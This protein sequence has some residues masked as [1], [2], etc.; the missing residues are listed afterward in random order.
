M[1]KEFVMAWD[2]NKDKLEAYIRTHNQEEYAY[3]YVGLVKIL[4]AFVINPFR[5]VNDTIPYD[6]DN[7]VTIDDGAYDGMQIFILHQNT[8]NPS[9][10]QYVYTNVWYGSCPYCDTLQGIHDYSLDRLP[11]EEQVND[12]MTL[13]LHLLQSCSRMIDGQDIDMDQDEYAA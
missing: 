8:Y 2:K 7:M 4:F 9:I 1:I 3:E 11:T 13:C 5:A 12:Y 10:G 6:V